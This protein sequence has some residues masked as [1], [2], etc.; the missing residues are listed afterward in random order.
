MLAVHNEADVLQ[1]NLDWYARAGFDTVAIDNESSDASSKICARA[2]KSGAIVRLRRLET[3]GF[4]RTRI[5]TELLELARAQDPDYVFLAAAD[6]FFE[7]A[8]GSDLRRAMEEDFAAGATVLEFHNMEFAITRA[9]VAD[10]PDPL[11]RMRHYSHRSTGMYRAYRCVE[12]LDIA[13][14]LGHRPVFPPDVEAVVSPR[15]YVSRH[16]PLRTPKQA[17]AKIKRVAYDPERDAGHQ[18]LHLSGRRGE[19]YAQ[20][21]DLARYDEDHVWDFR[22]HTQP[23]RARQTLHALRQA[24]RDLTEL[25]AAHRDL[26]SR[27]AELER[28]LERGQPGAQP[29]DT[30]S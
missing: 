22:A 20:R 7:V 21:K 27:H 14:K 23:R 9:D 18:Y 12:G 2:V 26:Q 1:R 25:Q 8:D 28:R 4:D 24:R 17:L 15:L 5:L 30:E 29:Q 3:G 13:A 6:E 16:Y 19:L 11:V 10:E